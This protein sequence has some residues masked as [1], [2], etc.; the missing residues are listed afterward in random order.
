MYKIKTLD[1]NFNKIIKKF[2][3]PDAFINCAY[4]KTSDW[5]QCSFSEITAKRMSKNIEIHMN[6]YAWL[7]KIV[8]DEMLKNKIKGYIIIKKT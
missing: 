8:A 6:S 4:P 1:K 2:G 7:S 5:D 3:C